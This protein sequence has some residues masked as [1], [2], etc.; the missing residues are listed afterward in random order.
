[1][2]KFTITTRAAQFAKLWGV[3]DLQVAVLADMEVDEVHLAKPQNMMFHT[4]FIGPFEDNKAFITTPLADNSGFQ[5]DLAVYED[6]DELESGPFK[7][8]SVLMPSGVTP[9]DET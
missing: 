7:G 8:Y 1:M 5:I 3:D 6:V 9:E 2:T 4:T